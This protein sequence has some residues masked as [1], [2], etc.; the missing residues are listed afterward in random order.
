M[1]TFC[2]WFVTVLVGVPYFIT[3]LLST[4][5]HFRTILEQLLAV[6]PG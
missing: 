3:V 1:I 5:H 2:R 4:I 6:F